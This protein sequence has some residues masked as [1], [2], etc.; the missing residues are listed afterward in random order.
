MSTAKDNQKLSRRSQKDFRFAQI[1]RLGG[2]LF[3]ANDLANLWQIKDANTLH[4][5]LKRYAAKGLLFRVYRGF[6]ALKP[7]NELDP[8]PLGIKALHGYVYL[9]TETILAQAGI[10]FQSGSA[11]TLVSSKSKKFKIGSYSY[12]SRKL[13]DKFLYNPI[14]ITEKSGVKMANTSRAVADLLY[15][16]PH[17]FFDAPQFINWQEV[18]KIQK[19]LGYPLT[20]KYY[21]ITKP[22]RRQA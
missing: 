21:D 10:I 20:P 7:I 22:K 3:H 6:Y 5:T 2:V 19:K 12:Y 11:I 9:S 13:A 17:T 1:S 18:K 15:F 4:T 14:G 16:N 8:L